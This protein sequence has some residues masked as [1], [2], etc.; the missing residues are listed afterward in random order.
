MRL[1]LK[2]REQHRVF[3]CHSLQ[4]FSKNPRTLETI[5]D[6]SEK[7]TQNFPSVKLELGFEFL[8]S[9]R[10]IMIFWVLAPSRLVLKY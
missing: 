10:M 9:I 4:K 3:P 2:V 6:W 5:L 1:N 7:I 8:N